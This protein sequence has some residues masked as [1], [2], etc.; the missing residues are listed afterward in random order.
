MIINFGNETFEINQFSQYEAIRY[1]K[2][3]RCECGCSD[4]EFRNSYDIVGYCDTPQGYMVVFE[5]L[6]CFEKYRHHIS[7]N[8][9]YNLDSF[10][11]DLGL[12]LY[13]KSRHN[14]E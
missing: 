4:F 3:L 13:L 5:C 10:K 7:S 14:R 6:K 9:R 1:S 8:N 12:K 11:D 2:E